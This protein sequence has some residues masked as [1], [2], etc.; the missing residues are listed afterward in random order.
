MR[1]A[2][3][4]MCSAILGP[5]G[6]YFPVVKREPGGQRADLLADRG[7]RLLV[8]DVGEHL[9]N[10]GADLLHFGLAEAAR[11]HGGRA[12]TDAAGIQGRVR[13]EGDGVFV[14]GDARA[15]ERLFRL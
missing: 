5:D 6:V 1:R 3:M 14:D 2:S 11:G 13:V 15:V 9:G 4:T 7:D 12:E 10:E 8:A